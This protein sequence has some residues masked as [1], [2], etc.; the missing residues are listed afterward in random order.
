M[1]Y[2]V[3]GLEPNA[4]GLH[5]LLGN[6]AEWV[7]GTGDERVVRGGHYLLPA[8]ELSADWRA[9]EDLSVWNASYPQHHPDDPGV[10]RDAPFVGF[11]LVCEVPG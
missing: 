9:V 6:A 2:P 5:D 3:G 10:R 11:R 8:A 4:L 7:T 1:T